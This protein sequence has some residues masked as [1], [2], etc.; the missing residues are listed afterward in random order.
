MKLDLGNLNLGA[1]Q[2]FFKNIWQDLRNKHLLPVAVG[3]V[4]ALIAVPVVLGRSSSSED[5][6]APTPMA[7]TGTTTGAQTD[8]VSLKANRPKGQERDGNASNP[9]QQRKSGKSAAATPSEGSGAPTGSG[10]APTSTTPTKT[11][12]PKKKKAEEPSIA[13]AIDIKFG[14]PGATKSQDDVSALTPFP[15]A[16]NAYV[17]YLGARES[18]KVAVFLISTDVKATG[19]G[20]CTPSE[21]NCKEVELR[22]GDTELFEVDDPTAGQFASYELKLIKIVKK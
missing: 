12:T 15:S 2:E 4:V 7:D 10:T 14:V 22:V 16:D 13:Y 11:E 6:V 3:L 19:D 21:T 1:V 20:V 18:G 5:T 8:P 17:V 9:F